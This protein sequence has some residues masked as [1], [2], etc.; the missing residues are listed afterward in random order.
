MARASTPLQREIRQTKPF[1]SAAHEA[2]I[3]LLRT[4]DLVQRLLASVIEPH[5]I[6]VQ[7]YNVLRILR[8]AGDAGMPTLAVAERMI[9]QAPGMTRLL[10][11]LELKGLIRR[12]RCR[13]D[14]RQ[15]L[16]WITGEGAVVLDGLDAPIREAQDAYMRALPDADCR[17]LVA[18][19]DR[20]RA[21]GLR[22]AGPDDSRGSGT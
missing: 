6:T 14:R 8:G 3:G 22:A 11:R 9:Q 21:H 16:C 10:D 18:L 20:I 15:H 4:A 12:E 13:A 5:G 19:L 1:Q 2:V 17:R 7:Q